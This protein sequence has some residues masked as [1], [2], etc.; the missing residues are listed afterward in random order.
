MDNP[1]TIVDIQVDNLWQG[2][3]L[4]RQ[5]IAL[6]QVS[7]FNRLLPVLPTTQAIASFFLDLYTRLS[8]DTTIHLYQCDASG[9]WFISYHIDPQQKVVSVFFYS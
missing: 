5:N 6:P 7:P 1:P 2:R 8:S 9:S 3:L 4:F